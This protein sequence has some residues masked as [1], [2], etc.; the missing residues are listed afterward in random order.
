MATPEHADARSEVELVGDL[1]EFRTA[2]REEIDAA[3]RMAASSG[4]QLLNGR[5]IGQ[6]ADAYQYAF[7]LDS[8]L[9]LPDDL[10]GV[11]VELERRFAPSRSFSGSRLPL[12]F[13]LVEGPSDD[14]E[15]D[16]KRSAER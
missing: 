7:S 8:V 2:L 5:L 12:S 15:P 14:K 16:K 13:E 1:N 9:N 4:I 11:L 3:R 6:A 10:P